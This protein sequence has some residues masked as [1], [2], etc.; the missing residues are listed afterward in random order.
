[1]SVRLIIRSKYD[2]LS[3]TYKKIADY[4]IFS[5]DELLKLTSLEI[6]K[7]CKTSSASVIRFVKFLGF[8]GLDE[9]KIYIAK[10]SKTD[11]KHIDPIISKNDNVNKMCEKL[12]ALV[13]SSNDDLFYQIDKEALKKSFE[14]IRKADNIYLLGIGASFL[15]AYDMFHKLRRI[16]LKANFYFDTHT[17]VEAFNYLTKKDLVIA[18]SYSGITKEIVYPSEIAVSKGAT[19][20]AVTR[21]KPN[22]LSKL[23]TILLTVPCNEELTRIGAIASKY[24]S[25]VISD[26]LYLGVIQKDFENIEK[27]LVNTSILTRKLKENVD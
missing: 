20:I 7:K 26:I 15:P 27:E 25:M 3:K 24:S 13:N 5:G 16:N 23:S 18:F 14:A 2:S 10:H 17:I 9:L 1:M 4:M 8:S 19:V 21:N 6:A 12:H 11:S 22:K